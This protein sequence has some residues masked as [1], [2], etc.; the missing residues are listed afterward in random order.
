MLVWYL[1]MDRLPG[2]KKSHQNQAYINST[3]Q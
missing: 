1:V 3:L 2:G